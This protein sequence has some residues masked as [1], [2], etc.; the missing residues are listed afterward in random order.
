MMFHAMI[1][2]IAQSQ[3]HVKMVNVTGSVLHAIKIVNP[4][5]A[6]IVLCKLVMDLQLTVV[7]AK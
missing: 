5:M 1:K 4:A 3:T 6:L 2:M 7:L